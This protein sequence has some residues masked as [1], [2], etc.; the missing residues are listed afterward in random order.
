M[1]S[2]EFNLAEALE[3]VMTQV[4]IPSKEHQVQLI[5]DLPDEVS[6]MNLYGD[7]I[8]HPAPGI[9]EKLIHE[10][11]YHSQ[12]ASREGLGLYMCQ[13]LVKIM[14]GTVQYVREAEKSSFIILIEF[15]L[16]LRTDC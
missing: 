9:P 7:R 13:K 2:G 11:F 6:S 3:A 15:P 1:K 5:R 12:G 8:T 4:M 14:N 10:M 16:A